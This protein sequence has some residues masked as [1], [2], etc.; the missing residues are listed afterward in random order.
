MK[1]LRFATR[2]LLGSRQ[3]R[4]DHRRSRQQ[5]AAPAPGIKRLF[6]NCLETD[7]TQDSEAPIFI[8]SAGWRSGSTLLQRLICSGEEVLIWGEP[9]DRA[10][11][12]QSLARM[13]A[14]FSTA[15]PPDDYAKPSDDLSVLASSWV[16]NLYPPEPALR[17]AHRAFLTALFAEPARAL[18]AQRWGFKEVRLGYAEALYLQALFPKA[19]FLF[20]RRKL[21]DAYRSYRDFSPGMAWY[22]DWPGAPVFTPYGFAKHW[23]RLSV[24]LARAARDT[25]GVLIEYEDLAAGA[26]DWARLSEY[27]GFPID[28]SVLKRKVGG[29]RAD[30][31]EQVSWLEQAGLALGRRAYRDQS[32]AQ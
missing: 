12:I 21:V 30:A 2:M 1:Q 31:A 24:E 9:Y 19:R 14:P 4:A 16:A 10:T 5:W 26:V 6:P 3:A 13:A 15:W 18:G 25:G 11:P 32:R 20:I 8:L 29:R 23:A 27:C 17:A 28:D 22:A 7:Q